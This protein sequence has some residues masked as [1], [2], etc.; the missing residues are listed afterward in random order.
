MTPD[1]GCEYV[2]VVNRAKSGCKKSLDEL[3][4]TVS[5]KLKT[6]I[7]RLT[8]D[9]NLTEDLLQDV[10]LQMV[11]S[12]GN[13]RQSEK[14]WPWLYRTAMGKVYQQKPKGKNSVHNRYDF[15]KSTKRRLRYSGHPGRRPDNRDEK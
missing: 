3:V 11:K 6:Y 2:Q 14:F 8:L 15:R 5:P 4:E 10:L 13:L 12:L 9:Q 1:D 7:Y